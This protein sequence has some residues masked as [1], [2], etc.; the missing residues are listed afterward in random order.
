M[1]KHPVFISVPEG[2]I[3]NPPVN[4]VLVDEGTQITITLQPV[5]STD[6]L[7]NI[8]VNGVVEYERVHQKN[9]VIQ[10]ILGPVFVTVEAVINEN[11]EYNVQVS[12]EK[13]LTWTDSSDQSCVI[14]T[15]R[16]SDHCCGV[17]SIRLSHQEDGSIVGTVSG[18][19][20]DVY[21]IMYYVMSGSPAIP[22]VQGKYR[23]TSWREDGPIITLTATSVASTAYEKIQ[24]SAVYKTIPQEIFDLHMS[25][26]ITRSMQNPLES[27]DSN[28]NIRASNIYGTDGWT[29]QEI[30]DD[31]G[32][33][34]TVPSGFNYHVYQLT[35]TKGAPVISLMH[36][37]LPIPGLV[38]ER[39][40]YLHD[41]NSIAGYY[42]T[43]A[44]GNGYF[45][46]DLCKVVGTS[47]KTDEYVPTVVGLPGEPLYVIG[48]QQPA[49]T[50]ELQLTVNLIGGVFS[51]DKTV[52]KVHTDSII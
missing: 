23:V 37:L 5:R 8:R 9:L 28:I 42:I 10:N 16:G 26:I 46:G 48:A 50:D 24:T 1:Q 43:V 6:V 17:K 36:N 12:S 31:L 15:S 21:D 22:G 13:D 11:E 40:D 47:S 14:S 52:A 4:P 44:K 45:S 27:P 49:A 19:A 33:E 20:G 18:L 35:V 39:K 3:V 29:V 51:I 2:V 38:I 25:N 30:L 41:T 7:I 32:I 34:A